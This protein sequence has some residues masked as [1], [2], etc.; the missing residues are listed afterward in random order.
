MRTH[1]L[2]IVLF[3][4]SFPTFSQ[5]SKDLIEKG[6]SAIDN[7]DYEI[8][9]DFY[10]KAAELGSSDACGV[11][12]MLYYNG[13]VKG[14]RYNEP[15]RASIRD[16][17][18]AE[19]W[20]N[21]AGLHKNPNADNVLGLI[22]YYNGDFDNAIEYIHYWKDEYIW[23]ESKIALAVCFIL[24][25]D[26]KTAKLLTKQVYDKLK[27]ENSK[28]NFYYCSCALLEYIEIQKHELYDDE[29]LKY[30]MEFGVFGEDGF[31]YCPLNEFITGWLQYS[32]I[33]SEFDYKTIGKARAEAASEYDYRYTKYQVL[34]PF[35]H[36]IKEFVEY[37]N[38]K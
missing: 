36:E 12:A 15:Q 27:N 19:L 32:I 33:S 3:V 7:Q 8:A 30:M 16:T 23:T 20:A 28:S 4:F 1:L 11:L 13:Y 2:I 29:V 14:D 22:S 24:K 35:A 17:E 9:V 6:A 5:T 21:R 34:Y 31:E 25:E 26:F 18:M 37:I 10:K 38:K